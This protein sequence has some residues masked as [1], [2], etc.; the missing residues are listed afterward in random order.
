MKKYVNQKDQ[1]LINLEQVKKKLSTGDRTVISD[2]LHIEEE[3]DKFIPIEETQ[4]DRVY[5]PEKM[6]S[7]VDLIKKANEL[8]GE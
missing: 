6:K 2:V 3:L 5:N 4:L 8:I 7:I 1:L